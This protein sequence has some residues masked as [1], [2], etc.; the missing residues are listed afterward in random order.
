MLEPKVLIHSDQ[1]ELALGVLK[2]THP[3]LSPEVCTDY[4]SLQT[5]VNHFNPEVV[6]TCRFSSDEFPRAILIEHESVKWV[7]NAGSGVNHLLP[8]DKSKI[9]VTNTAG[10]AADMMAEYALGVMLYFSLDIPGLQQDQH[11][12]RWRYRTVNPVYGK[13]LLI[14]GLG[15]T[16]QAMAKKAKALDMTVIGVRARVKATEH[17]DEIYSTDQLHS[18]FAQADFTL[19]C[20]PLLKSTEGMIGVDEFASMKPGA[21]LIDVSRGGI[22]QQKA[23]I[24]ALDNGLL[25]GAGLDV[26]ETEPLPG[27]N[28]LWDYSNV[29]I[30]PHCSSVYE[31]WEKRSAEMFAANLTRWRNSERLLNVVDPGRGY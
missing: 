25:G 24:N 28:P 22:V 13:T 30:S 21:I 29:L 9:T 14:L 17:V 10:V 7:S 3:D 20:M 16:G 8:W 5:C 31:G 15:K 27:D 6:F 2:T 1:P 23:L 26:F 12:H 4:S 18:A 19:V 11:N